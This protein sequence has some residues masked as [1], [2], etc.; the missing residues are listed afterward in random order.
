MQAGDVERQ[1]PHDGEAVGAVALAVAGL[2]SSSMVT[3]STQCR[4]FSIAQC[5]RA[6]RPKRSADSFRLST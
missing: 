6:T 1:A 4:L 2:G 3:S 5:E